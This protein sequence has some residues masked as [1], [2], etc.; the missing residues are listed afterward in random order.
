M[1]DKPPKRG[2]LIRLLNAGA[3]VPED[4]AEPG[5]AAPSSSIKIRRM[6]R[7]AREMARCKIPFQHQGRSLAGV[8]C[9]GLIVCAAYAA[10]IRDLPDR[11]DYPR[12]PIGRELEQALDDYCIRILHPECGAIALIRFIDRSRHV[13]LLTPRQMIH[14][15][16][17]VGWVC[18][19][20]Y[21]PWFQTR[22]TKLY[23]LPGLEQ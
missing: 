13:A 23:R 6:V 20:H 5:E 14:A 8:D 22:T 10:G 3:A 7:V 11:R 18:C 21:G 19:H 17:K 16:D 1:R 2:A 4:F 12:D 9:I 15:W